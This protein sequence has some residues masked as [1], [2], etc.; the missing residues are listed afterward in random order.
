MPVLFVPGMSR[1]E[2]EKAYEN[3]PR[4]HIRRFT[5]LRGARKWTMRRRTILSTWI[6][7]NGR[8]ALWQKH[9]RFGYDSGKHFEAEG[10]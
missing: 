3:F 2:A 4:P 8:P 7:I 5:R 10:R 6:R 1:E 9:R